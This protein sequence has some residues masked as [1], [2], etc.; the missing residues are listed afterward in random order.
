MQSGP[1]ID[2]DLPVGVLLAAGYG[3]RFDAQGKRNKLLEPLEDGRSVAWHSARTLA[4]ALPGAVAVVRPDQQELAQELRE[5]GCRIVA[6]ARAEAGMGAALAAAV[7]ET[8]GARGWVVAL[9]DMPWV[10]LELIRAVA[11]SIVTPQAIAAPWRNGRRGH[12]VGFG[13]QWRDE[14]QRLQG[15]Q[16]ARTLLETHTVTRI[17]TDDDGAFRDI[18]TPADLPGKLSGKPAG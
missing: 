18:D 9:A 16:G 11:L 6:T 17:L 10:P 14:L 1:L 3:R 15:D 4:T 5:A 8:A 13:A 7:D 12:P 2:T